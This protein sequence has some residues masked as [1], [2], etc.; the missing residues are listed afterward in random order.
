MNNETI[1]LF[2]FG[3]HT[4]HGMFDIAVNPS[5]LCVDANLD[6]IVDTPTV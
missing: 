3:L 6:C 5:L 1:Q 4:H 2:F